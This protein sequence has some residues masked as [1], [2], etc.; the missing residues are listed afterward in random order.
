M[1]IVA[2]IK[3]GVKKGVV[4]LGFSPDGKYLS[5]SCMDDD[6]KVV[7]FNVTDI[8]NPVVHFIE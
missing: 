5:A 8:A 3:N 2:T 4:N 7:V 1:E 6:H